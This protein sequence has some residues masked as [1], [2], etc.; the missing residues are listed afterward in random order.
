VKVQIAQLIVSEDIS[1]NV[2][3]VITT[4]QDANPDEWVLFPEGM[5]SG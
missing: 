3:K 5:I 2:S 4:L 1:S